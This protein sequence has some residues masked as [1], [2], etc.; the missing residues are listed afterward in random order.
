[1]KKLLLTDRALEDI[2]EIEEYSVTK[3]G[4]KVADKYLDD[5]ESGLKLLQENSGLLQEFEG[6]SGKLKY[7]RVKNHFL[8]CTEIGNKLVV[9]T[10]KHVQMD[11]INLLGKLESTLALEVDLLFRLLEDSKFIW[12]CFCTKQTKIGGLFDNDAVYLF[13]IGDTM[14]GKWKVEKKGGVCFYI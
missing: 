11:I 12:F 4:K 5:I 9:L 6:F 3:W 13:A 14:M 2:A 10:V 7:Y 8:I 1:M